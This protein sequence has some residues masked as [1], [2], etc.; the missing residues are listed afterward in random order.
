MWRMSEAQ[1][2]A[3]GFTHA[4]WVGWIPVWLDL[5]HPEC[6]T[7]CAQAALLDPVLDVWIAAQGLWRRVRGLRPGL[8]VF[9]GARIAPA[10]GLGA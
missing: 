5:A 10:G 7:L 6:P 4:G 3:V 9:V 2:Q 8:S 1:A